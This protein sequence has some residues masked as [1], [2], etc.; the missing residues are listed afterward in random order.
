MLAGLR[1]QS[2]GR[3]AHKQGRERGHVGTWRVGCLAPT[4]KSA[5][6]ASLF[7]R[8]GRMAAPAHCHE[9]SCV[10]VYPVLLLSLP[11]QGL[12]PTSAS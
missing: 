5:C 4:L 3:G 8:G 6:L 1:V 7:A 12:R 10:R 9:L 11:S 2:Q